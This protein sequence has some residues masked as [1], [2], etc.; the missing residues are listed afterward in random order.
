MIIANAFQCHNDYVD[1]GMRY[2]SGTE[3]KVLMCAVRH[4]LGW[5]NSIERRENKITVTTFSTI[6]GLSRGAVSN[7]LTDLV[8]FG[9][10]TRLN[11]STW[12]LNECPDWERL[13]QR[14]QERLEKAQ[15]RTAK[16]RSKNPRNDSPTD[17]TN[18]SPTDK[19][20]TVRLTNVDSPTD[21]LKP[22]RKANESHV[23]KQPP[24]SPSKPSKK[25]MPSAGEQLKARIGEHPIYK[26]Y[27][28]A[29]LDVFVSYPTLTQ[30]RA[31]EADRVI[32]ALEAEAITPAMVQRRTKLRLEQ[33]S[34]YDFAWLE[35][36]VDEL[37][38]AAPAPPVYFFAQPIVDQLTP[39]ERA[40]AKEDGVRVRAQLAAL[41]AEREAQVP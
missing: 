8:R 41:A 5:E 22:Y 35:D 7:A 12:R 28:A 15:E 36:D 11:R 29:H 40:A 6:T 23:G 13:Q 18:D 37:R 26:A 16:A 24:K 33:N 32:A 38:E 30:K 34:R 27:I 4:I 9:F 10:M 31:K 39:E 1:K 14:E 20:L 2:L 3:F 25:K 17:K 19:K 21:T